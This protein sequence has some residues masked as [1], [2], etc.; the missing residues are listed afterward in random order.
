MKVYV[1]N[2]TQCAHKKKKTEK[3]TD[4]SLTFF[5]S[6]VCELKFFSHKQ[7]SSEPTNC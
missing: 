6:I 1:K 2:H 4:V 7:L 3:Q 5:R